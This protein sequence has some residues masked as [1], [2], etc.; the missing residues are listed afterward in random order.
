MAKFQWEATTRAGESRKGVIEAESADIVETRLRA[1]GMTIKRVKKEAK[2]IV[3]SFGSGVQPRDL[4][5]FTR[6]LATMIDAGLP[7]VQCLDILAA[8]TPNKIF[9]RVLYSVKS[10]VEQGSTFSE[11][12]RKHPKVFDD[13]YVNLVAA[14]E[15]GGILDTI[16]NRLSTYIEKAVKLRGQLKSAMVYPIGILVVAIGVIAVMLIKVIPTFEAMFKEF[17]NAKLPGPTQVVINISHSFLNRWYMYVGSI[18]GLF[19]GTGMLRRTDRGKE[20]FDRMLL[21]LPVMG[22]VLR[23]IVVARFTRTL[24]TLL[25]SGVPI[26]DALDI[27]AR[28]AGNRVVSAGISKARDK[29]AEGHDMAGPL[30]EARVVPV[31]G[32]ADDRRRR[33]DRRDGPDAPEGRRLLRRRGRHRG[34]RHDLADR[35]GDDGVPRR[36]RRWL[37]HRDV[38]AD[39]Q[40][41]RQ[42]LRVTPPADPLLAAPADLRGRVS[43]LLLLRT[44]VISVVLGMSLWL[45]VMGDAPSRAAVWLQS[46]IIAATLPVVDR[47]RR[48]AAARRRAG[49]DRAATAR[50]R[51]RGDLD[52]G[53]RDRRRPE[54]VHVP[55]R[56][57][58]RQRGA[59]SC[60]GAARSA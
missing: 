24:G 22:P 47:V 55:V 14:G 5:I 26:L 59:C 6:Q 32:R 43:R 27:C 9:Q 54:P 42:Y 31:D 29:I 41:R 15:V 25:S 28:T 4:Q 11:A 30:A 50:D 53:L 36:R 51:C 19:V 52:A 2:Q 34:R 12:L 45:L 8:Q 38:P 35:A 37:D 48:G 1:E 33:A 21:R 44:L 18:V 57:V 10:T 40:A 7:L 39:L 20:T 13:L 58:D 23:K 60:T 46:S 17:G 3:I 49:A 56:A 16:L